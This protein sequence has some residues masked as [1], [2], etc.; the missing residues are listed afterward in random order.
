MRFLTLSLLGL[1]LLASP[2]T[3][4]LSAQEKS[5]SKPAKLED[6]FQSLFNGQDLSGWK[7]N[8]ELWSAE[9]GMIVGRTTAEKPL[10]FNTFLIYDESPVAN[11]ELRLDY[12]IQK[13]NSGIQYRSKV[14]DEEKF[15]VGGYQAD[16]DS[17]RTYV[18]INYEERARGILAE[19]GQS[20]TIAE[21]G[22]K[23]VEDFGDR[24]EL[25]KKVDLEGWN[26]YVVIANGNKLS[27]YING[28]LMSEVID[29]QSDK[30]SA[31]GVLAFQVHQGPA[32]VVQFKNIRIK[33]LGE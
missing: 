28:E 9:E 25:G 8:M 5:Q 4:Q 11:F 33:T 2:L 23:T 31:S 12:K 15:I 20:V 7:G 22:T 16:I 17:G 27:H 18:G 21:D 32:M 13:G 14:L 26:K 19:R 10:E 1:S 3:G 30:A 24:A 6:G 29:N